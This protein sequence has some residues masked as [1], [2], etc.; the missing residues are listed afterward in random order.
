VG[1]EGTAFAPE[2]LEIASIAGGA[3]LPLP[4]PRQAVALLAQTAFAAVDWRPPGPWQ[5]PSY[6]LIEPR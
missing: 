3:Y 4:H 2:P 5:P 6:R 1:F